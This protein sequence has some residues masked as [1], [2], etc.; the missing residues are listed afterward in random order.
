MIIDGSFGEGRGQ[1][2]RSSLLLAA[3]VDVPVKIENIR[4]NRPKQ[5]LM[6][7]AL[8]AGDRERREHHADFADR[9]ARAFGRRSGRKLKPL[10]LWGDRGFGLLFL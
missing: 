10:S 7:R 8:F 4:A 5:G 9:A 1:I 6:N 3:V 2:L